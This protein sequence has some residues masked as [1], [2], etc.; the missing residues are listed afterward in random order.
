MSEENFKS[1][2]GLANLI[3]EAKE[4]Y[5]TQKYDKAI[6]LYGDLLENLSEGDYKRIMTLRY[7][8]CLIELE[9]HKE[10]NEVINEQIKGKRPKDEKIDEISM[11]FV[12]LRGKLY[13]NAG[14]IINS[15]NPE[16]CSKFHKEALKDFIYLSNKL[17]KI[18]SPDFRQLKGKIIRRYAIALIESQEYGRAKQELDKW[19]NS[20]D[21]KDDKI[22]KGYTHYIRGLASYNQGVLGEPKYLEEALKDLDNALEASDEDILDL[23]NCEE[24]QIVTDYDSPDE[25]ETNIEK[26]IDVLKEVK[27]IS[28]GPYQHL[29]LM[30]KANIYDALGDYENGDIFAQKAILFLKEK[31]NGNGGTPELKRK[32][33]DIKEKNKKRINKRQEKKTEQ[34]NIENFLQDPEHILM[35]AGSLIKTKDQKNAKAALHYLEMLEKQGQQTEISKGTLNYNKGLTKTILAIKKYTENDISSEQIAEEKKN[36][37][38][39]EAIKD[40]EELSK[41]DY[42]AHPKAQTYLGLAYLVRSI[43]G[44][45][46]EFDKQFL[47]K[48]KGEFAAAREILKKKTKNRTSEE[49]EALLLATYSLECFKKIDMFEKDETIPKTETG[50]KTLRRNAKEKSL[51]TE[52]EI[53][54]LLSL[55]PAIFRKNRKDFGKEAFD[56]TEQ[57]EIN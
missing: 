39:N 52:E 42:E 13:Q 3:L 6:T 16:K 57:E 9:R 17:D 19:L 26:F 54:Q 22:D 34:T 14:N 23:D 18:K 36:K 8:D 53:N 41:E 31:A 38:L 20:E 5:L 47:I 15:S 12:Y 50:S 35:L 33:K 11:G 55:V 10:A 40:F 43:T 25:K 49:H 56:K 30:A 44:Q 4:L 37:L 7:T 51:M 32:I 48:A 24:V 1:E 27:W 28:D 2:E 29:Y 21:N 46:N 45:E